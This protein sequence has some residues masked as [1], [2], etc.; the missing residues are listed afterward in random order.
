MFGSQEAYSIQNG[1]VK[2]LMK[3][4][5]ISGNAFDVLKSVDMVGNDFEYDI[6]TGY[7][8][9][10]QPAKVDGGGPHIRCTALLG[11]LQ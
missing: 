9:K 6:G 4:A 10:F 3:G 8:G 5:S 7:C 1:E 2:E 11:G